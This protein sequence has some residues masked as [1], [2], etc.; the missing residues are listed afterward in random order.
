MAYFHFQPMPAF[1]PHSLPVVVRPAPQDI[2]PSSD[3]ALK[4]S[5]TAL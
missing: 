3:K 5:A 1:T 4:V 2:L